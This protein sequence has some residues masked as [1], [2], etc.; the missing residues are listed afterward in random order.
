VDCCFYVRSIKDHGHLPLDHV[1]GDNS[2]S[3]MSTKSNILLVGSGGVGTMAA[4]NI[5]AGGL[6]MVTAVLRSNY[7]A[8]TQNGFTITSLDHGYIKA[9]K[10][11]KSKTTQI[12]CRIS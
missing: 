12:L 4:Y 5:D 6:A 7:E 2:T 1:T 10:P 8:V 11:T 9:W 3:T